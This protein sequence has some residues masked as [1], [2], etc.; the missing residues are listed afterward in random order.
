MGYYHRDL[1]SSNIF[2]GSDGQVK[3][4]D[5]GLAKFIDTRMSKHLTT[6]VVTRWYRA[7]ELLL[8]DKAY[9]GKIDI[10][11][12]GCIW[13]EVLT[14]GHGPFRGCDDNETLSLITRRCQFP[15]YS[16]WPELEGLLMR[17]KRTDL[18]VHSRFDKSMSIRSFLETHGYLWN[19]CDDFSL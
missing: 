15:S 5:F 10:W 18:Y 3:L 9:T 2:V 4:G 11:S 13:I 6:S 16:E 14:H 17:S 7:P 19:S 8:D 12:I 1:K